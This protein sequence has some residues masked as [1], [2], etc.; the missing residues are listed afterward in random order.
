MCSICN[1]TYHYQCLSESLKKYES[2]ETIECYH[3]R[4]RFIDPL[5]KVK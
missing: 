2:K 4:M 5:N 1:R 3:C